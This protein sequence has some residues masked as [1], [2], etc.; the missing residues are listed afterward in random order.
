MEKEKNSKG[1]R[2]NTFLLMLILIVQIAVLCGFGV[3]YKSLKPAI[4]DLK[5]VLQNARSITSSVTDMMPAVGGTLEKAE[6]VST[7]ITSLMPQLEETLS[8]AN[9][10]STSVSDM[11]PDLRKTAENLRSLSGKLRDIMSGA[12]KTVN[13]ETMNAI[14]NLSGLFS[15]FGN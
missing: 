11:L 4:S 10:I 12:E 3:V 7:S 6:N 15:M 5:S 2:I 14:S 9:G 1:S 8:N 13:S